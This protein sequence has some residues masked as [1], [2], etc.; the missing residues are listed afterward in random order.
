[1]LEGELETA[2]NALFPSASIELLDG[3]DV[4]RVAVR[5][6]SGVTACYCLLPIVEQQDQYDGLD[7]AARI[8]RSGV[9]R[10]LPVGVRSGPCAVVATAGGERYLVALDLPRAGDTAH[11][12]DAARRVLG[13]L[14]RMHAAFAGFPARLT[15]SLGLVPLGQWLA[16]ARPGQGVPPEVADG[17]RAFAE[18]AP[19][20]WATVDA[21]LRHPAPLVD[22]LRDCQPTIVQGRVDPAALTIADDAITFHDWGSATRGPGTLDLGAFVAAAGPVGGLDVAG[23]VESY[24]AE[25]AAL[26]RLPATGDR[27]EREAALGLLAGVLRSG[28]RIGTRTEPIDVWCEVVERGRAVLE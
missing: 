28:W 19:A 20:A 18:R 2:L 27:W 6:A 7:R 16:G 13:A 9:L 10:A 17:W 3:P 12:A 5:D 24:R 8:V 1:M 25:R 22:A 14:A 4:Y 15:T 11:D 21:L 26:G 23:C